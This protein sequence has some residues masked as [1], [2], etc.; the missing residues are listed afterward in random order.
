M[1]QSHAGSI[2][3][4]PHRALCD[5]MNEFQSHAGSIEAVSS[6]SSKS[7]SSKFQSHAGSIEALIQDYHDLFILSV[8][9][10]RWF[11]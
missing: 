7:G 1:F 11:D 2:E 9:I 10:P 4:H 6:S 5:K 3:A 8:S